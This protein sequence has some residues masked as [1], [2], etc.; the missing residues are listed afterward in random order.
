MPRWGGVLKGGMGRPRNKSLTGA[1][2]H[3]ETLDRLPL[4]AAPFS[5][6]CCAPGLLFCTLPIPPSHLFL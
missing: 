4:P 2:A 1:E 3:M 6:A 5:A